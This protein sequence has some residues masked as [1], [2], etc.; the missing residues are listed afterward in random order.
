MQLSVVDK[1]GQAADE[2][3]DKIRE[4]LFG[5]QLQGI[6]EQLTRLEAHLENGIGQLR[7]ELRKATSQ[8][9]A[10]REKDNKALGERLDHLEAEFAGELQ[11]LRA[12]T[13]QRFDDLDT[14]V[15]SQ[16]KELFG[17]LDKEG[18]RLQREK[19]GREA[20]SDLLLKL[21]SSLREGKG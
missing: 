13:G 14:Q 1:K 19:V 16:H 20:M 18:D 17:A 6:N 10:A 21:A 11:S 2:G 7:D 15:S 9:A 12:Q 8:E 4:L 5:Q 3:M